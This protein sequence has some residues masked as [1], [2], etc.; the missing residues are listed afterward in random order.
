MQVKKRG[1]AECIKK[2]VGGS[3]NMETDR[4]KRKDR[5]CRIIKENLEERGSGLHF[6]EGETEG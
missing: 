2:I 6:W 3:F 4:D 1:R 5:L